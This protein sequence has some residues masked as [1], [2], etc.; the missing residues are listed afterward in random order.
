MDYFNDRPFHT[1]KNKGVKNLIRRENQIIFS[2]FFGRYI[3]SFQ[4]KFHLILINYLEKQN[5]LSSVICFSIKYILI[6]ECLDIW[7]GKEDNN[8]P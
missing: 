7:I 6:W 5:V 2:A 1:K 8:T 3:F 4:G